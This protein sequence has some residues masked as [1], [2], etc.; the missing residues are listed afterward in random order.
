VT[1]RAER[2]EVF[3][4][5]VAQFAARREVVNLKIFRSSTALAAPSVAPEH[6]AA[7]PTVRFRLKP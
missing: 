4:G 5:V 7:Q 3:V 6:L 2:N 1:V